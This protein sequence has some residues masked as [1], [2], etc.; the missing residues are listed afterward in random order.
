MRQLTFLQ[1]NR[2]WVLFVLALVVPLVVA[3][4]LVPFRGE[5]A[6]AAAALIFVAAIVVL[7]IEGTRFVGFVAA[8]SSALWFDFFLTKPFERLAISQRPDIETTICLLVVGLMVSE[9]AA[10]SRHFVRV[11]SEESEFISMV[12]ELAGLAN[13]SAPNEELIAAA[14]SSM[15]QVLDLRGCRFDAELIDPPLARIGSHGEV[16]HVGL[17]WPVEQ[18]GIPGPEAEILAQWCGRTLGRFVLT[19]TPG[20]PISRERREVA[21]L[22]AS[23]TAAALAGQ[24][25]VV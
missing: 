18:M 2:Q 14:V 11:S 21:S 25:R 1:R 19:P 13:Q 9:L 7:S 4:V 3:A 6:G 15:M 22:L 24:P 20:E 23:V 10:R 17:H 5:F 8:L 12:R 16:V